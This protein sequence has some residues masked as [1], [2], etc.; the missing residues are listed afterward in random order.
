[1]GNIKGT[2]FELY[3]KTYIKNLYSNIQRTLLRFSE[4][5]S[6]VITKTYWALKKEEILNMIVFVIFCNHNIR[7]TYSKY[8]QNNI[9]ETNIPSEAQRSTT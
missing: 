9:Y 5:Y 1:M 6:A 2:Y 4:N 8:L 7:G 3:I